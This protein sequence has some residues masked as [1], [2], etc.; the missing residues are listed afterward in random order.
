[1]ENSSEENHSPPT[2]DSE[3]E[4]ELKLYEV[5]QRSKENGN[6]D[7]RLP[8]TLA[9]GDEFPIWA[10]MA[11]YFL[12]LRVHPKRVSRLQQLDSMSKPRHSVNAEMVSNEP[13][14]RPSGF[15]STR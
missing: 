15:L 4:D 7:A 3:G 1:M 8:S 12:L 11:P 13:L 2:Q 10:I 14:T 6:D 5:A 9:R